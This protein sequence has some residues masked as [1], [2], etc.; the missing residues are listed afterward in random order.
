MVTN[1]GMDTE[2]EEEVIITATLEHNQDDLS[3]HLDP[4]I[5]LPNEVYQVLATD[6]VTFAK[7]FPCWVS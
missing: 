5:D 1:T 3:L 4:S 6:Y 7:S 2:T